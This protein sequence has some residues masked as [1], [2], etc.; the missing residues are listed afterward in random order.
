ML[1]GGQIK[2]ASR[3]PTTPSSCRSDNESPVQEGPAMSDKQAPYSGAARPVCPPPNQQPF[4]ARQHDISPYA[5]EQAAPAPVADLQQQAH[6]LRE[7]S[8]GAYLYASNAQVFK[9]TLDVA[10][11][12]QYLTDLV[13]QAG[14]P[15]D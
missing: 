9:G 13:H 15:T 6:C 5:A 3:Q 7:R 14:A 11:Y 8:A 1:V 12:D 2:R 4:P 10:G